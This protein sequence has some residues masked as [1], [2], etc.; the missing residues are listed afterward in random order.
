MAALICSDGAQD[1]CSEE[2]LKLIQVS[3]A[4]MKLELKPIAVSKLCCPVCWELLSILEGKPPSVTRG[5]HST[6]YFQ[7]LP[8]WLPRQV[9]EKMLKRFRMFAAVELGRAHRKH[10]SPRSHA[11]TPSEETAY[12]ASIDSDNFKLG[13][14]T[15]LNLAWFGST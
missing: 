8:S 12:A 1:Q 10:T 6:L 2:L 5:R 14:D 4:K 11:Q 3:K 9:L 13:E 7:H 15:Y